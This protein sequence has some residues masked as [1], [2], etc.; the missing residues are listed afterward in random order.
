MVERMCREMVEKNSDRTWVCCSS[1][2]SGQTETQKERLRQREN[3]GWQRKCQGKPKKRSRRCKSK[4]SP[5]AHVSSWD[6]WWTGVYSL[7]MLVRKKLALVRNM[8][9][10]VKCSWRKRDWLNGGNYA[11]WRQKCWCFLLCFLK[12]ASLKCIYGRMFVVCVC[13]W[14][15]E[16]A[17]NMLER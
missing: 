10:T 14:Q 7:N 3:K 13:V 6:C 8:E 1:L 12:Y 5:I 16:W 11:A 2:R 4:W 17:V 9:S 15:I